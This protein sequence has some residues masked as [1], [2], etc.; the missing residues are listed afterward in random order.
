MGGRSYF[1]IPSFSI[2]KT[3]C[4]IQHEWSLGSYKIQHLSEESDGLDIIS[5]NKSNEILI[6]YD[7]KYKSNNIGEPLKWKHFFFN[8]SVLNSSIG[9]HMR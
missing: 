3:S 2:K 6:A 5:F 1:A 8:Q 7:K 4:F 9:S